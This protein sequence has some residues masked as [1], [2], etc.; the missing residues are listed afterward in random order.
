M[1]NYKPLYL[2]SLEDAIRSN[3]KEL[4][5]ESYKENC[6][7]ARKIERAITDAYNYGKSCLDACAKPVIEQYGFDRVNWVLAN[8]VQQKNEDGRFSQENKAWARQIYIPH[9]EVRWH[10]CVE[11][12]PGLTDIFINE[13][14]KLCESLGLFNAEQCESEKDGQLEY[15]GK[16][17][18]LKGSS[19]REQYKKPE[20]QLFLA[21]SGFGCHPNARGRKVFGKFLIDGEET[22][23]Q[24]SDFIGILKDEYLPDWAK[25]NLAEI[26]SSCENDEIVMG[27]I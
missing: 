13:S 19:L 10:F 26:Q 6:D 4:W 1:Q 23:F 20:Y 12:H 14:R 24:R 15:E 8:T 21:E 5:R 17:L 22:H 11:S 3:E 27:G 16:V 25:D 2:W 9:D 7:C 18:V